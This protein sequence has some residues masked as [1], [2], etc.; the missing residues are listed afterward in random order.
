M[1]PPFFMD[2]LSPQE[3]ADIRRWYVYGACAYSTMALLL[4]AMVVLR[5]DHVQSQMTRFAPNGKAVA[6]ESR[7]AAACAAQDLKLVT[8]IEQLGER[9]EVPGETLAD[10]FFTMTRAREL[11]RAGRVAEALAVY[12]SNPIRPAQAAAK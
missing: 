11:C 3:R 12:R 8:L 6:A 5:T 4:V 9:Q 1:R 2:E 10:A 7:G